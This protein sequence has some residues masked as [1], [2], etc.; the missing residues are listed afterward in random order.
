MSRKVIFIS[1]EICSGKDTVMN[2]DYSADFYQQIDL[3]QLV[4]E[5]FQTADR[6]FDNNLEPYF[7]ERVLE[8]TKN[9]DKTYIITGLRQP[10]LAAKLAELF[11]E[12]KHIYLS[13]PR[14]ILKWRYSSRADIKDANISFE[15]AIKGDQSLGMKELQYYLLTEVKCDFINNY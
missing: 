9:N 5:K 2:R 4:R 3:G 1:G 11:D 6:I 12:V 7:V 15:D 14:D 13:V 10:T 8:I